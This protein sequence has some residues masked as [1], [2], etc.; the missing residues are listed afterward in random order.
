MNSLLSSRLRSLYDLLYVHYGPQHWWP[1]EDPFEVI[2]GA[3]LTQNTNW[4]NV[5]KA[6]LNLKEAGL[7]SPR[8]LWN[9]PVRQ[10][11]GKIRP[12][13]YYR[14]K[15]E[16][17]RC[18]LE[19]LFTEYSGDLSLLFRDE[20][21]V[22]REKLLGVR[23]IGPETADSILLYAAGKPIFVVDA[24]TRRILSRHN[25]CEPESSYEGIQALFMDNLRR[26]VPLFNEYHALLVQLGKSHCTPKPKCGNCPLR[27]FE[28]SSVKTWAPEA[29]E[30]APV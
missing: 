6:I 11:S 30:K 13:G 12:S 24:Y 16:R 27:E 28:G 23:G 20:L 17:I 25:L 4:R 18:F 9:T 26:E 1:A 10:W 22:L 3:I 2:L 8:I 15:A 14:I 5:E 19:F 21:P 29:V 7:L